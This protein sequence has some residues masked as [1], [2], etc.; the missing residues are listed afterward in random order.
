MCYIYIYAAPCQRSATRRSHA[1]QCSLGLGSWR[2]VDVSV[3]VWLALGFC[4]AFWFV[5]LSPR[6][7]RGCGC[8]A[9]R[10]AARRPRFLAHLSRPARSRPPRRP[11]PAE[12]GSREDTRDAETSPDAA[13]EGRT[14]KRTNKTCRNPPPTPHTGARAENEIER[15][16][17]PRARSLS[18]GGRT[19]AGRKPKPHP[20]RFFIV[21]FMPAKPRPGRAARPDAAPGPAPAARRRLR[22]LRYFIRTSYSL[23]LYSYSALCSK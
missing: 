18:Q 11:R 1:R 4:A 21:I 19:R 6:F 5:I 3:L 14:G 15:V 8:T 20:F 23:E 22:R 13:R 16:Q 12:P 10:A 7:K 17:R 2:L 9:G